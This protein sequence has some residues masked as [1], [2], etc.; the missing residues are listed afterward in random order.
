MDLSR[1]YRA[2]P[3]SWGCIELEMIEYVVNPEILKIG[4][5][6]YSE[7]TTIFNGG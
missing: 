3:V 4:V 5:H 7:N 2:H 6:T 1:F